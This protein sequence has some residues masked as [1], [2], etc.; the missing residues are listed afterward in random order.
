[1]TDVRHDLSRATVRPPI[2]PRDTGHGRLGLDDTISRTWILTASVAWPI[3]YVA[4]W[5]LEPAADN[6]DAVAGTVESLF[7]LAFLGS[8]A[9]MARGFSLR[10]RFGFAGSL[11]AAGVLLAAVVAC[12]ITGHHAI[13]GW[14]YGQIAAVGG[15]VAISAAGL[16]AASRTD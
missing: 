1:M 7:A 6:P 14:W 10:Q 9:V 12:P 3:L 13:G 15:L 2:P 8:I 4:G 16:R 11:A 5:I